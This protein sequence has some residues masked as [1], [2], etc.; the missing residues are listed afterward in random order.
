MPP[1][2]FASKVI[3]LAPKVMPRTGLIVSVLSFPVADVTHMSPLFQIL[4]YRYRKEMKKEE[5]DS[6]RRTEKETN[7]LSSAEEREAGTRRCEGAQ[8][9][10]HRANQ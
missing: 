6:R 8:S 7:I 10:G 9:G 5:K 2:S 1:A 4:I 3:P